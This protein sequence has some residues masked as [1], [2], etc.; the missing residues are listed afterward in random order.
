MALPT[1]RLIKV[2][3]SE[4]S[5]WPSLWWP[6]AIPPCAVLISPVP[7]QDPSGDPGD[8]GDFPVTYSLGDHQPSLIC[9]LCNW[10]IG[11]WL[12]VSLRIWENFNI[13]NIINIY[14]NSRMMLYEPFTATIYLWNAGSPWVSPRDFGESS[15][16]HFPARP[17]VTRAPPC[18]GLLGSKW[19]AWHL[20]RWKGTDPVVWTAASW[21]GFDHFMNCLMLYPFLVIFIDFPSILCFIINLP[22]FIVFQFYCNTVDDFLMAWTMVTSVKSQHFPH[23]NHPSPSQQS[24][25]RTATWAWRTSTW[26]PPAAPSRSAPA[27]TSRTAPRRSGDFSDDP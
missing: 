25:P 11:E 16:E 20:G 19:W 27:R 7:E 18:Q 4:A 2:W 24:L 5:S 21:L 15:Q 3:V 23:R 13:I 9:N 22:F 8:P 10:S 14:F 26:P 6:W 17:R 12:N 1:S